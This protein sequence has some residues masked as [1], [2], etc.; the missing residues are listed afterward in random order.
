VKEG[1][2][3]CPSVCERKARVFSCIHVCFHALKWRF[4]AQRLVR[5]AVPAQATE[6]R[7]WI[8]PGRFFALHTRI[9]KHP[10]S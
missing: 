1:N 8:R 3:V 7:M 9:I 2:Y 4:A 10:A 6:I 5:A